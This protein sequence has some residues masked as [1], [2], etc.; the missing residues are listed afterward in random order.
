MKRCA[1]CGEWKDEE[2]LNW[3]VTGRKRQSICRSCSVGDRKEWYDSHAETVKE[4]TARDR[5]DNIEAAQRYVYEILSYSRCADCGEYD[6]A[7]LTFDHVRGKKKM[8]VS[9]K[10][11]HGYSIQAIKEE[12]TKCEVVCFNCH[13]RRENERRDRYRK[14]LVFLS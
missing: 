14:P 6:F 5:R 1:R 11:A 2:E 10:A 4:K 9:Q 8:E 7:V 13:M 3:K 12:L